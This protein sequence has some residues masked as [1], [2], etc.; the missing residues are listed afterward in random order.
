MKDREILTFT[1]CLQKNIRRELSR[2]P[3][4]GCVTWTCSGSHTDLCTGDFLYS[5]EIIAAHMQKLDW[6]SLSDFS[7]LRKEGAVIEKLM[8][9]ALKNRNTYKG[10]LFLSLILAQSYM[11]GIQQ[12]NL[13]AYIRQFCLPVF[14]DYDQSSHFRS[15]KLHTL[16]VRD[17]RRIACSGFAELFSINQALKEEKEND[18][19]RTV[20]LIATIDDTTTIHRSD[21][22][23]LRYV[24]QWAASLLK[25]P[26]DSAEFQEGACRL[27][28]FYLTNNLTS[29]GVADLFILSHMLDELF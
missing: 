27:N 10:L 16:G 15:A 21:I 12:R 3:G 20:L 26:H 13:S 29:G 4:F 14:K 6:E 24:Q 2:F 28:Q 22:A 9:N 1:D 25:L 5:G 11:K 19:L 7:L 17:I 23:T 8:L 18:L